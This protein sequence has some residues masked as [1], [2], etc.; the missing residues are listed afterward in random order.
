M[1]NIGLFLWMFMA[2]L[3][4]N[5]QQTGCACPDD[6]DY[7]NRL[8]IGLMGFEY[9]NPVEGYKGKQFFNSWTFGEVA[10][11]GGDLIRN[12]YL[13]Y[14][15]YQDLLLWLRKSDFKAGILNK[16]AVTGFRLYDNR[17][18]VSAIFAKKRVAVPYLGTS[19]VFLQVL[20]PGEVTLYAYRS[21]SVMS[22][23]NR[24]VEY[25]R[26]LISVGGND[27]WIRLKRKS[28]IGIPEIN[29]SAMKGILRSNNIA[30]N[31]SEQGFIRALSLYNAAHQP[32]NLSTD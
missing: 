32:S 6:D 9:K 20:E 30:V 4:V 1:K 2:A 31:G 3:R 18:N 25:S 10:L 17:N 14:D 7:G 13:Q 22:G 27:Y 16:D 5:A 23:D 24:L 15:Q 28:L 19:D 29:A 8:Q 26:Y 21:S 11:Q 12:I